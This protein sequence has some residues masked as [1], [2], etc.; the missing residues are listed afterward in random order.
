MVLAFVTSKAANGDYHTNP[1]RLHHHYVSEIAVSSD[2]HT[3][4][5]PLKMDFLKGSYMQPFSALFEATGIFFKDAGNNISRHM[6]ANGYAVFA[7]DLSEDLA[8]SENHLS[9]PRQGNLRI[10]LQFAT[11]LTENVNLI[12]LS[13]FDSVVELDKSRNCILDFAS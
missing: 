5:L 11:P 1:F 2:A 6:F 13:E 12:I 10:A 8:G 9:L 7:F 3:N 4:I